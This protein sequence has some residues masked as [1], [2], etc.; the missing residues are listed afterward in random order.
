MSFRQPLHHK[1]SLKTI[2]APAIGAFV[3]APPIGVLLFAVHPCNPS[4][5]I[6]AFAT[7]RR[8]RYD[9][10]STHGRSRCISNNS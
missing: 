1:I 6:D 4:S 2:P 7:I 8:Y 9:R 5:D 3:S 10:F